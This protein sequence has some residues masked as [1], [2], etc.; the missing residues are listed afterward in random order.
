MNLTK[1][2]KGHKAIMGGLLIL[3]VII[4]GV[5]S[6]IATSGQA[7]DTESNIKKVT[8]LSVNDYSNGGETVSANG[9]VESLEQAELRSQV[10]APV[11]SIKVSIGDKVKAGQTLVTLENAD[12]NAQLNQAKA[13]LKVQQANLDQ[14]KTGARA[15]ELELAQIRVDT[16]KQSL[17]DAQKQEDLLVQNAYN[18]LLNSSI[19]AL[20]DDN[21]SV[22]ATISGTYTGTK[23]GEYAVTIYP[24]SNGANFSVSG[25]SSNTGVVATRPV[26]MADGLYISFSSTNM[27]GI[28]SW[29]IKIPNTKAPN[30]LANYSV[31]QNALAGRDAAINSATSALNSAESSLAL[32]KAGATPDQIKAQ[33]AAVEQAT[34]NVQAISVQL[35]KTVISSPISGEVSA[36]PVKYGE[37]ITAGESV[38]SIVNQSGLQ[39]KSYISNSDLPLVEAGAS[40]DIGN[41]VKG[42]VSRVSPSIDPK[43]KTVEVD[44]LVTNPEASNLIV[45]QSVTAKIAGKA[46]DTTGIV[47]LL[48]LQ[49]VKVDSNTAYVYTVDENSLLQEN[50][51]ILGDVKGEYIEVK[52]GIIPGMNIVSTVYELKNGEKVTVE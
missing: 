7:S 38:V 19:E 1:Y 18:S 24:T 27:S 47:Y 41:G 31:Y 39:I 51:V 22:S 16:A 35:Q 9:T 13:N 46:K 2:I 29:K 25:L 49:A 43:T 5:V 42:V 21:Y 17:A 10:M 50:K 52:G 44:I 8:L 48:P 15:E 30:Y 23:E 40:V 11:A 14:L 37:L 28:E 36:L 32:T 26:P 45:G 33:E 3:V 6:R 12:L 34:A 20:P 4:T